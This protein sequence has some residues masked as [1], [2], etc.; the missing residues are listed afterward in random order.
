MSEREP[1][2][3]ENTVTRITLPKDSRPK[4][5]PELPGYDF[6]VETQLETGSTVVAAPKRIPGKLRELWHNSH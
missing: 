2:P 4:S 3:S 1:T 6:I 5:D